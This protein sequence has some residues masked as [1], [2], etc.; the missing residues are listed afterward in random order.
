MDARNLQTNLAVNKYLHTVAP[1][2]ISS[3]Y[4][5]I[6]FTEVQ[7][8]SSVCAVATCTWL[9]APLRLNLSERKTWEIERDNILMAE[10]SLK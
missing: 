1:R 8:L 3:T 2:W 9:P 6:Q 5:L 10:L 7:R 4:I